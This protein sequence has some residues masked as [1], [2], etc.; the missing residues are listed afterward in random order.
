VQSIIISY[1]AHFTHVRRD[2]STVDGPASGN[3]I[4][5]ERH[6]IAE[7]QIGDVTREVGFLSND[8][9]NPDTNPKTLMTLVLTLADQH[10]DFVRRYFVTLYETIPAP[11]TVQ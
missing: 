4:G 9:T 7:G 2:Y 5:P 10:D 6:V 11:S 3:A 1:Q 8:Y